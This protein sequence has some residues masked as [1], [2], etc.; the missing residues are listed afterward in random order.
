MQWLLTAR[1]EGH[2]PMP[3]YHIHVANG[4]KKIDPRAVELPDAESAKRHAER[5][6]AGLT[7]LSSGF[8]VSR[9]RDCQVKVTDKKGRTLARYD[10]CGARQFGATP[11]RSEVQRRLRS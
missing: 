10:L 7:A 3:L 8:G 11:G 6:A 2:A 5:I 4:G 1:Q 9:L